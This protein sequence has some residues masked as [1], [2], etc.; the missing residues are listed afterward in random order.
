MSKI[1][2]D[3]VHRDD[4]RM[5]EAY[6][7]YVKRVFSMADF[8]EWHNRG[9]WPDGYTPV[10]A[11]V[12]GEIV[13]N[14][15][16]AK[17]GLLVD[18]APV[19]GIQLGAVGTVPEYRGKGLSRMVMDYV[20]EQFAETVDIMFLFGN[21]DVV[22]FYP[23]FG[24]EA[25]H[26][27]VFVRDS[28][29][30]KGNLR[31]RRLDINDPNDWAFLCD[32]IARRAPLTRLFGAVEYDF[33]TTWHVI[34]LH[35]EHVW[36]VDEADCIAIV[37]ERDGVVTVWDLIFDE[38]VDVDSVVASVIQS[39]A[40]REVQYYF[41]ADVV[42][43]KHDRTVAPEDSHLFVR[44]ELPIAGREFKFPSTAET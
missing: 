16:V 14:V 17:M 38:P 20:M 9:C 32:R 40:V 3:T 12:G 44:G 5:R 8:R 42:E 26:E 4:V 1:T 18:G 28:V 41:S 29:A 39:D 13:S 2:I 25:H 36:Y 21:D 7:A 35:R 37:S 30:P 27:Q 43:F 11:M 31:A 10:S 23:R 15:S 24:F 6:F 22:E 19:R 33:V 34:N